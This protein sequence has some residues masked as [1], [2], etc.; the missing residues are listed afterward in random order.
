M[1]AVEPIT[2]KMQNKAATHHK[3]MLHPPI[4]LLCMTNIKCHLLL[5][6]LLVVECHHCLLGLSIHRLQQHVVDTCG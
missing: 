6:L 3:L 4:L 5:L 2:D 1:S